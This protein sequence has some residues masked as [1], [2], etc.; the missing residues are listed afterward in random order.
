MA[1][2]WMVGGWGNRIASGNTAQHCALLRS[3]IAIR[4]QVPYYGIDSTCPFRSLAPYCI[5]HS[6]PVQPLSRVQGVTYT[7]ML[8]VFLNTIL[9]LQCG[10]TRQLRPA[11]PYAVC[12][13]VRRVPSS[14]HLDSLYILRPLM[15]GSSTCTQ[16]APPDPPGPC[17]RCC[18]DAPPHGHASSSPRL[19]HARFS[20]PMF[21]L[22]LNLQRVLFRNAHNLQ[23][24]RPSDQVAIRS[25]RLVTAHSALASLARATVA[26]VLSTNGDA[27]Y[28]PMVLQASLQPYQ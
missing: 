1:R 17:G 18:C 20:I 16:H 10:T 28:W 9:Y 4:M 3:H 8:I 12:A 19:R 22:S 5:R 21:E 11:Y 7:V 27:G 6:K 2:G 24:T 26:G 25:R 14:P 13:T 23:S 15:V